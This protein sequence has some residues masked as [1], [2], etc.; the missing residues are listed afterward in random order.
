M[1]QLALPFLPTR[2]PAQIRIRLQQA[3]R[4]I[5]TYGDSPQMDQLC[6]GFPISI[7]QAIEQLLNRYGAILPFIMIKHFLCPLVLRLLTN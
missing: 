2:S 6:G 1:N 4:G 7:C 5:P 3:Y